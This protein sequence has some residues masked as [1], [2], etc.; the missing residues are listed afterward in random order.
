M[1]KRC[2]RDRLYSP[3]LCAVF[4]EPPLAQ[5]REISRNIVD[6]GMQAGYL[7][8]DHAVAG[9]GAKFCQ[10]LRARLYGKHMRGNGDLSAVPA[11]SLI[12]I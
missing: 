11:L 2:I 8:D 4:N 3:A 7:I 9:L 12:H 6:A 10:R 1:V 5:K